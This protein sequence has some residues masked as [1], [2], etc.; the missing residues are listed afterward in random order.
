M[1]RI[2][3]LTLAVTAGVLTACSHEDQEK[4]RQDAHRAEQEIR[5]DARAAGQEIKK[6]L[7][8]ADRELQESMEKGRAAAQHTA[9][10]IRRELSDD[11][12]ARSDRQQDE[13]RH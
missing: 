11:R 10:E 7:H 4:A 1:M 13:Q 5:Q 9:K 6:D 12:A 2:S 8:A 3:F